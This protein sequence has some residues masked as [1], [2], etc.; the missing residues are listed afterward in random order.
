MHPMFVKLFLDPDVDELLAD[1]EERRRRAKLARHHRSRMTMRVTASPQD[2][3]P[4]R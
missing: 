1:E 4:P 2:R 3:R